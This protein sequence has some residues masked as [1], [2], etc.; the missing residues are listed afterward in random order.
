MRQTFQPPYQPVMS[1]HAILS[2]YG[3][4]GDRDT[5]SSA[6]GAPSIDI[7]RGDLKYSLHLPSTLAQTPH[8]QSSLTPSSSDLVPPYTI[9]LGFTLENPDAWITPFRYCRL[10]S[11][12]LNPQP[13]TLV[14]LPTRLSCQVLGCKSSGLYQQVHP[15]CCHCESKQSSAL[16]LPT[17][18]YSPTRSC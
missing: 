4:F 17:A 14:I 12:T 7:M 2:R 8:P 1:C 10:S 16:L 3:I 11:V 6:A 5:V 15:L 9:C 18:Q 13:L